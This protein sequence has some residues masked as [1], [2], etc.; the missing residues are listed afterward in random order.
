M[1]AWDGSDVL[2]KT[3]QDRLDQEM[4]LVHMPKGVRRSSG[5]EKDTWPTLA[6]RIETAGLSPKQV[7]VCW[8]KQVEANPK[9]LGEF[10]AHA[11]A[12]QA[13]ITAILNIAKQHYPNLRVVYFSSRTFGGWSGRESGSPEPY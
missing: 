9:P 3:K 7:Q 6:K 5:L 12:L 4:D 2:P 10:P 11:R 1:G 8:L 13:D